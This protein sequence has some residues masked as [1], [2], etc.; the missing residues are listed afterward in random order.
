MTVEEAREALRSGKRIRMVVG[1]G[2]EDPTL[3]LYL[4]GLMVMSESVAGWSAGVVEPVC[5]LTSDF[6]VAYLDKRLSIE[7][8]P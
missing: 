5:S 4:D 1:D 8:E 7:V 3:I 6:L 2:D